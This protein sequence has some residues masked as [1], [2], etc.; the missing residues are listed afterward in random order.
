MI[1]CPYFSRVS[2]VRKKSEDKVRTIR[3]KKVVFDKYKE[4]LV[5]TLILE[6]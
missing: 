6:H 4:K 3:Q 5:N 2:T 1:L